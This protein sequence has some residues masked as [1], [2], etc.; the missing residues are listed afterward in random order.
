MDEGAKEL[1]FVKE[2]SGMSEARKAGEQFR[3]PEL[4]ALTRWF[5]PFALGSEE[6]LWA[7]RPPSPEAQPAVLAS[8]GTF[9]I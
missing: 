1:P 3:S 4:I 9:V 7:G 8:R 6:A 5:P 2:I